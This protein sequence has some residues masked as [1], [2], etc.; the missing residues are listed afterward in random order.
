MDKEIL[1]LM[2]DVDELIFRPPDKLDDGFLICEC[3]CVSVGDI[4]DLCQ[5]ATDLTLIQ[6]KLNLG[7]GCQLCLKSKDDWMNNIF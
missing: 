6:Q 1:C 5:T 7:Q 3:F 4:R 2:D